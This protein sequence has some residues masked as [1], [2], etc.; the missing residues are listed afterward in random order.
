MLVDVDMEIALTLCDVCP[1]SEISGLAEILL[2][3]F[4]SRGKI[5]QLLKA[6]ID[7]EVTMTGKQNKKKLKEYKI[8]ML[9][10][11][12]IEQE[13]TLFRGTT[14]A[15]R[16]LS[17]YAK[18]TC[19]DYI[20]ITLLPVME[21]INNLPED[22]LTW[23]LDPQKLNPHENATKNKQNVLRVTENLL[24]AICSSVNNAPM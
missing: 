18:F 3:C 17:I 14:M 15:T 22:Q 13:A 23:E 21:F 10:F 11:Y 12:S 5:I 20:R 9:H 6:I 8:V 16:I 7:R 19:V 1:S 24:E 2:I 4:E